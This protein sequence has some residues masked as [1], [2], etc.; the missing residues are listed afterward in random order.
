MGKARLKNASLCFPIRRRQNVRIN[1]NCCR[2]LHA[3]LVASYSSCSPF[4]ILISKPGGAKSHTFTTCRSNTNITLVFCSREVQRSVLLIAV[5]GDAINNLI[6]CF[7]PLLVSPFPLPFLPPSS[8]HPQTAHK[9][10]RGETNATGQAGVQQ[11]PFQ[12][13]AAVGLPL[14]VS[15]WQGGSKLKLLSKAA[16]S[17]SRKQW[18][19]QG[20]SVLF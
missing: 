3:L 15:D 12:S 17:I 4:P 5:S 8:S 7:P 9:L 14:G 2:T 18:Q 20:S 19:I 13:S 6:Q 16:W 1:I 11:G 10:P